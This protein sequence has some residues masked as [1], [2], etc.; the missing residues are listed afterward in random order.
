MR[1]K[2]KKGLEREPMATEGQLWGDGWSEGGDGVKW[3]TGGKGGQQREKKRGGKSVARGE[4]WREGAGRQNE[5][6]MKTGRQSRQVVQGLLRHPGEQRCV[7]VCVCVCVCGCHGSCHPGQFIILTH[8]V[9]N[10]SGCLIK[11]L[12]CLVT[13][14]LSIIQRTFTKSPLVSLTHTH[15]HVHR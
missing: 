5:L 14:S 9:S 4:R 15:R 1:G 6:V 10:P 8:L 13:H 12:S 11:P 7:C 3:L 2:Y